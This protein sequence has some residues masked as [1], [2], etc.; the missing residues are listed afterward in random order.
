MFTDR[1]EEVIVTEKVPPA[2]DEP[3]TFKSHDLKRLRRFIR[4]N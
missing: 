2:T 4:I 3:I 1:V